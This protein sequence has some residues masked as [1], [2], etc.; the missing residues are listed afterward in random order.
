MNLHL[1][2]YLIPNSELAHRDYEVGTTIQIQPSSATL[3]LLIINL[4]AK[5]QSQVLQM[6]IAHKTVDSAQKLVNQSF[7][8]LPIQGNYQ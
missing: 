5:A 3:R 6:T 8:R 1:A 2:T 7:R 4:H